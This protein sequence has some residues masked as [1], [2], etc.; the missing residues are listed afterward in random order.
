MCS[1][2][3]FLGL[4]AFLAAG[5]LA[6]GFFAAGF[7]AFLAAGFLAALA[8]L[9]L[10]FLAFLALG[11]L[12]LGFLALGSLAGS[13]KDPAPFLPAAA[14]DTNFLTESIFLRD[15]RT[16]TAALAASTLLLATMYL[17]MAWREEPFLSARA[18][19]AVLIIAA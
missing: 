18:L 14:A 3:A 6:A 11:F 7:L 8:F 4:A 17:R 1:I 15:R 19:M 16:R 9:A 12:A 2:Y 5:F 10:G 13:L